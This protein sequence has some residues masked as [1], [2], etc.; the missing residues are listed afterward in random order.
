MDA[1]S[2]H[3]IA[4]T[5]LRLRPLAPDDAARLAALADDLDVARQTA[6]LPH[7]YTLDDARSFIAAQGDPPRG[8]VN[9]AV[10]LAGEGLIGVMG[11][12]PE[13]GSPWPEFGYWLGR[14]YWGAGL[15]TE[16]AAAA[17]A[18]AHG[19]GR[20]AVTAGHFTDNPASGRVLEKAGFL[21]TGV[22]RPD[23]SLARAEPSEAR[24][25][26]WLA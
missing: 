10:E 9:F 24:E 16:A 1:R 8:A 11:F 15:A 4:A 21:Y 6:A 13:P 5:R 23:R 7:P 12:R 14:P 26:V 19:R 25:M 18:W 3:T 2:D 22:R 20:R 17:L